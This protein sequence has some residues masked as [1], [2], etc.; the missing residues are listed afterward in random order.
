MRQYRAFSEAETWKDV[1]EELQ[2][3]GCRP[4]SADAAALGA[5]LDAAQQ[6]PY[7]YPYP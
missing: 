1:E 5:V 7:P 6:V 3:E 4:V 2:A